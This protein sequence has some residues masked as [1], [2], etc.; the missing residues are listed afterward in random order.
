MKF[1]RYVIRHLLHHN[2]QSCSSGSQETQDAQATFSSESTPTVW[3]SIPTLKC[4]QDN[5]ETF[6]KTP[7]FAPVKHGI[8]K[9]LEKL[10]KWCM[11]TD[12]SDMYF[13]CLGKP[14][15]L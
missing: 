5:W 3:K 13:I 9:G 14:Y 7:K 1:F 12:Q 15:L 2:I 10:C 8:E 6:S 11:A 4:L